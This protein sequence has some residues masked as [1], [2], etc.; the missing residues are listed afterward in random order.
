MNT[1]AFCSIAF[2]DDPIEDV[3]PRV[4][5]AGY[6]AVEIFGGHITGKSDD[7]LKAVKA[8]AEDIGLDVL[9]LSPYFWLTQDQKLL[10]ESMGIAERTV[11][12]AHLLDCRK[13]RTFTDAGPTGIGSEAA[14]SAL[15]RQGVQALQTITALDRG[16]N[17]VVETHGKTLADTPEST[18]RLMDEVGAP[19]LKVLFQPSTFLDAGLLESYHRLERHV[20]HMHIHNVKPEGGIGPVQEGLIDYP[21]FFREVLARGYRGSLSVEYV[22]RDVP[23][24]EV[25]RACEYLKKCLGR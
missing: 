14:T 18:E 12:A 13:I 5:A 8:L 16:I 19:N 20:D 11:H 3:L 7:D 6:D 22:W 2:R 25:D 1:L 21:A 4:S 24:D 9:V 17:F 10:R 23:W 15:R